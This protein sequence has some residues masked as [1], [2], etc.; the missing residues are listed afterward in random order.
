MEGFGEG[1][2][3]DSVMIFSASMPEPGNKFARAITMPL[4]SAE[5]GCSGIFSRAC[6]KVM[7]SLVGACRRAA[8][9]AMVTIPMR[10]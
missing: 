10:S 7:R 2:C 1:P 9:L 8:V 3:S 6:I 5:P 4:P